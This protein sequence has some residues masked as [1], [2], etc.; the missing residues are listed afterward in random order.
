MATGAPHRCRSYAF[1]GATFPRDGGKSVAADI[2]KRYPDMRWVEGRHL[3]AGRRNV[4]H[5]WVPVAT[6]D[7]NETAAAVITAVRGAFEAGPRGHALVF[8][9]DTASATAMHEDL[10]EVRHRVSAFMLC[11]RA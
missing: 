5:A 2:R 9:R 4:S 8:C 10:Q 6:G 3:H 7:R 1:V 11:M